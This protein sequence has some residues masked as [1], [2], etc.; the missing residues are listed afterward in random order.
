MTRSCARSLQLARFAQLWHGF[1]VA[2]T[3]LERAFQAFGTRSPSQLFLCLLVISCAVYLR[4]PYTNFIFDEQEALLKNPFLQGDAGLANA[5]FVDF[6]GRDPAHTIGSYRPLPNIFWK[7]IASVLHL[8]S[9]FWFSVLNLVAHAGCGVLL[10]AVIKTILRSSQ[11][12]EHRDLSAAALGNWCALLFVAHGIVSEAVCSVVGLADILVG[13]FSLSALFF[14]LKLWSWRGHNRADAWLCALGGGLLFNAMLLGLWSKETMVGSMLWLLV[15]APILYATSLCDASEETRQASGGSIKLPSRWRSLGVRFSF[16]F[17]L[18]ALSFVAYVELRKVWFPTLLDG[19]SRLQIGGH[20]PYVAAF[21]D[22]FSAPP[23]P[24]DPLNNPLFGAAPALRLPT[25]C[26][27]FFKQLLQM[28]LP[29]P[30]VGDYAYPRELPHGWGVSA[31]LGLVTFSLIASLGVVLGARA[32]LACLLDRSSLRLS[33]P[34]ILMTVGSLLLCVYYVPISNVLVLLPTI[35]AERLLYVPV[36]GL[37]MLSAGVLLMFRRYAWLM[38][39]GKYAFFSYL[40]LIASAGRAHAWTYNNDVSFWRA[41]TQLQPAS[42]KS[43]LNLGIML[44]ARGD[45]D[46]RERL[47]RK[48]LELAPKWD[49]AQIYLADVLC[50]KN[51]MTRAKPYYSAGLKQ[52]PQSRPLVTLALQCIWDR[53]AYPAYRNELDAIA[54]NAPHSWLAYLLYELDEHGVANA[55]IPQRYRQS[56]YNRAP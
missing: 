4:S 15:L 9:P 34:Q 5:F 43:Y 11:A 16:V 18:A 38:R 41:T 39:Y 21:F 49:L 52:A 6:W 53:G 12:G 10:A 30:L 48:A 24:V 33:A 46:A 20:I 8:R 44:G 22:W 7:L 50:R 26:G 47:T 45:L 2:D 28:I 17:A 56:G 35:R 51:Q 32:I 42:A 55:G 27:L 3:R 31:A 40:L 37:M 23:R 14:M 54:A 19:A 29:W 13:I 1:F 36:L 25:A